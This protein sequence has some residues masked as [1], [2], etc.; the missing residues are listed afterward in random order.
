MTISLFYW[1]PAPW[2]ECELCF[3]GPGFV[4]LGNELRITLSVFFIEFGI[5]LK[6][7]ENV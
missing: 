5:V 3:I 2:R 6:R 1:F 7:K 4:N